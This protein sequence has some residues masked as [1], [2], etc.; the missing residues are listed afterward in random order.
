MNH[1]FTLPAHPRA[2]TLDAMTFFCLLQ[3]RSQRSFIHFGLLVGRKAEKEEIH[4]QRRR[5]RALKAFPI[6]VFAYRTSTTDVRK[7]EVTA[8]T[9][10]I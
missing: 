6:A 4:R 5:P 1:V 3:H 2:R 8:G 9:A 7:A 10:Y